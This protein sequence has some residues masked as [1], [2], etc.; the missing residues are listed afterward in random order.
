MQTGSAA[1]CPAM[2]SFPESQWRTFKSRVP[3]G[4]RMA[5][6]GTV[7]SSPRCPG[8][9]RCRCELLRPSP[10]GCRGVCSAAAAGRMRPAPGP[11]E[12]WS[13]WAPR[14]APWGPTKKQDLALKEQAQ[15]GASQLED[16]PPAAPLR[17]RRRLCPDSGGCLSSEP[18]QGQPANL[19]SSRG[20][21]KGLLSTGS[22]AT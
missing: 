7:Q 9:F 3:Q 14:R 20:Q 17:A 12:P 5:S 15:L 1:G 13:A 2:F 22:H 21:K 19:E 10:P 18:S 4:K 16:H 11:R 8:S 6:R